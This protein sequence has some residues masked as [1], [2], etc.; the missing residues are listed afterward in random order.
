[1]RDA[2]HG[3]ACTTDL[4]EAAMH[5]RRRRMQAFEDAYDEAM[6]LLQTDDEGL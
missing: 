2:F 3:Y 1:M 4:Q 6:K 5:L